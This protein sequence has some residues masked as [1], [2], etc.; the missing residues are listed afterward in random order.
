MRARQ[1][2]AVLRRSGWLLLLLLAACAEA[3]DDTVLTFWAMGREGEAVRAL[4]P[5]FERQHPGLRVRVQ[6]VPWSAAH[7]KLLT[8]VAGDTLPDVFQVGNTWIAELAALDALT[9][10]DGPPGVAWPVED[11]F[12]GLLASSQVEGRLMA[13]PWYVDTRLLFYRKDLL[14]KAGIERLP[15]DWSGWLAAMGKVRAWADAG[16]FALLLPSNEWQPPVILAMQAGSTLLREGDRY[17][18]FRGPAFRKAFAFYLDLYRQGFAPPLAEAQMT[19]LYQEFAQGRFAFYI[20]GPWNIGEFQ[21]RLPPAAQALWETAVM[22]GPDGTNAPGLSLA[23]GASLALSRTARQPE[24]ARALLAF[25]TEP[26]RMAEFYRLTGDL[27]ARRS[28]WAHPAFAAAPHTAAFRRQLDAVRPT[29]NIPEWERIAA[30]ISRYAELAV[31]GRLSDA[32]ALTALD[33]DVD[34]I[35]AKRRWL[36]DRS[37]P[38][39][40]AP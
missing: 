23:G 30:K 3:P 10:L 28:A 11:C 9:P 18:D 33:R 31:R 5:E 7:E 12:P 16:Q 29:P 2:G 38:A 37:L 27:P 40:S 17:G 36:L 35:L 39:A 20:T 6:P 1:G 25:L 34:Q 14:A 19:N 15:E 26:A 13:W 4:L 24:A 21:R 8:A 22:P 32:E